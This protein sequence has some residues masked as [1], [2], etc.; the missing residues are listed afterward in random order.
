MQKTVEGLHVVRKVSAVVLHV[1]TFDIGD[2]RHHGLQMQE[3]GVALVGLNYQILALAQRSIGACLIEQTADDK[4]WILTCLT[5]DR[6]NQA[7]GCRFAMR[8]G[9]RDAK[10]VAHEFRQHLSSR[11]HWNAALSSGD[12]FRVVLGHRG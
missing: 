12:T 3:G 6:G 2:Q 10:S 5:Q 9:N 11:Y 1:V 8:T 4:S 7:S